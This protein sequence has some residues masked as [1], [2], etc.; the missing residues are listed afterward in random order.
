MDKFIQLGEKF[1]LEWEKL[2]KFVRE[3]EDY[4]LPANLKNELATISVIFFFLVVNLFQFI[5]GHKTR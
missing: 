2:P 3:E 5:L 1:G 4:K